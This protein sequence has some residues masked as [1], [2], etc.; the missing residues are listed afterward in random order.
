[1]VTLPYHR[2]LPNTLSS[3]R[4]RNE[5]S[6]R[7]LG[8]DVWKFCLIL[9]LCFDF[10]TVFW[11]LTLLS[12]SFAHP[13]PKQWC[14]TKLHLLLNFKYIKIPAVPCFN[15]IDEL[16]KCKKLVLKDVLPLNP[17]WWR[18][19]ASLSFP[20]SLNKSPPNDSDC[21][22]SAYPFYCFPI[23]LHHEHCYSL[24]GSLQ[25]FKT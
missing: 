6:E 24:Q 13:Q 5:R 25:Y 8:M 1:M 18:L 16:F 22:Y 15:P 20:P 10:T 2:L 7:L 21:C 14:C 23:I 9:Q 17:C 12:L 11:E 4:T 19:S 3:V